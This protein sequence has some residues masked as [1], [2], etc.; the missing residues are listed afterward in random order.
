MDWKHDAA[1]NAYTLTKED[2]RC[3][4]W[5]MLGAWQA[6]VSYRG[7]AMTGYNFTTAEAAVEWCE[8]QLAEK[9]WP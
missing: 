3:R 7:E 2:T 6:I 9:A 8:Q 5:R 4:V 1:N